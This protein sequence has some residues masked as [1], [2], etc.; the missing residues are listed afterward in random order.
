LASITKN[1]DEEIRQ[2]YILEPDSFPFNLMNIN[3]LKS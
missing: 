1:F 2:N 3:M